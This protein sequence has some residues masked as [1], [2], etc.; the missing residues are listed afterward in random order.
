MTGTVAGMDDQVL[1][2]DG[3]VIGTRAQLTRRR[4]LDATAK[5]LGQH[6]VLDVKVVDITREVGTSPATFYQYFSDV[7]DAI[8]ALA[9]DAV[10]DVKPLTQ[11][12][13]ASWAGPDGM[14][15]I[16]ALVDGYV[17]YWDEHQAI[18]RVRNLKAEEGDSRFRASRLRAYTQLMAGLVEQVKAGQAAGHVSTD[19]DPYATAAAMS[20]IL[21]RLIPYR[22]ELGRRGVTDDALRATIAT[23]FRLVLTG[24]RG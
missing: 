18:I 3:R 12:L 16:A 8:L 15:H 5:V 23:I 2:T 13:T 9:D 7:E 4:L 22:A 17:T 19:L 24:R 6:G 11:H 14:V 1:A 21:E 20:A 10:E